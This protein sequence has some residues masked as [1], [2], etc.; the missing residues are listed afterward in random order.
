MSS[1]APSMLLQRWAAVLCSFLRPNVTCNASSPHSVGVSS[2]WTSHWLPSCGQVL[3]RRYGKEADIWSCG[4]ILYILL[5][6]VPPFWGETEQQIFDAV[7]KG[8][9]DFKTDPWPNVSSE[10]KDAV[11]VMLQQ[12][13]LNALCKAGGDIMLS[14]IRRVV[15]L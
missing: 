5:S 11:R 14:A 12:A 2:V 15:A 10:A 9:I 13:S 1:A 4:V 6:G 8:H 3:K 7:A